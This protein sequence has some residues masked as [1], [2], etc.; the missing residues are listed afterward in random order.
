MILGHPSGRAAAITALT[1]SLDRAEGCDRAV[2]DHIVFVLT[3]VG[4]VEAHASVMR[5]V[6]AGRI[7]P[8]WEPRPA[9][10]PGTLHARPWATARCAGTSGHPATGLASIEAGCYHAQTL[11]NEEGLC[12]AP[13]SA[14][15]PARP[16]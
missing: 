16:V 10:A 9:T 8:W 11:L 2:D 7:T 4:A 6:A 13:E 5:A 3:A 14:H 1:A 15:P 12:D